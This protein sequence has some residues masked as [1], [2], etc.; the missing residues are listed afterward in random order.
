MQ[1][2]SPSKLGRP[3]RTVR[4]LCHGSQRDRDGPTCS[5]GR[6]SNAPAHWADDVVKSTWFCCSARVRRWHRPPVRCTAAIASGYRVTFTVPTSPSARRLLTQLGHYSERAICDC[7]LPPD[8][9]GNAKVRLG[10]AERAVLSPRAHPTP[11]YFAA[12]QACSINDSVIRALSALLEP[13]QE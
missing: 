10:Y 4:Q 12:A 5:R 9:S 11:F 1:A 13:C 3:L 2:N 8:R 6:R 7:R